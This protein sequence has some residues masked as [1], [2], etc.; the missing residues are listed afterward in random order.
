MKQILIQIVC[1][2]KTLTM[3]QIYA[4]TGSPQSLMADIDLTNCNCTAFPNTNAYFN[5]NAHVIAAFNFARRAEESQFGLPTGALGNFVLP[6]NYTKM[7]DYQKGLYLINSERTSRSGIN[8]GFGSVLGLPLQ[9]ID[10]NLINLAQLH[11]QSMQIYNYFDHQNAII[12]EPDAHTRTEIKF[13]SQIE[14][15]TRVENIYVTCGGFNTQIIEQALFSWIYQDA[16]S[17]WSHRATVFIQN[18]DPITNGKGYNDNY[19]QTGSEGIIGFGILRD[20]SFPLYCVSVSQAVDKQNNVNTQNTLMAGNLV[21]MLIIDPSKT[22]VVTPLISNLIKFELKKV[23]NNVKL[24]W[25]AI[26]E[27]NNEDFIIEKSTDNKVFTKIGL[28]KNEN[29]GS[30][31]ENFEFEDINISFGINYYRLR[32]SELAGKFSFSPTK[33]IEILKSA[34]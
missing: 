29:S 12:N 25:T 34:F 31:I 23:N 6:E 4:Q 28:I 11:T 8:F 21:S 27:P 32:Q 3:S 18:R 19:G 2:L 1:V 33:Y 7:S 16:S 24:F 30:D 5:T 13:G 14:F 22:F 10:V 20:I 17:G 26:S 15:N 9:D